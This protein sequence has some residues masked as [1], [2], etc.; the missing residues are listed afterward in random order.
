MLARG[1]REGDE[2]GDW[3]QHKYSIDAINMYKID[4]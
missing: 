3:D 1:E 2:F 4:K